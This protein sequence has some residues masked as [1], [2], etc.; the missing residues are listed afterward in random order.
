M[1]Q[2]LAQVW[3]TDW[4]LR[5]SLG[6]GAGVLISSTHPGAEHEGVEGPKTTRDAVTRKKGGRTVWA[7]HTVSSC[8]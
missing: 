5:L 7:R 1:M 3:N 2:Y 8:F 6:W 4:H